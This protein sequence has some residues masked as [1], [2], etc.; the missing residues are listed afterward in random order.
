MK[1]PSFQFVYW[2]PRWL[3]PSA[4]H[5]CSLMDVPYPAQRALN[6]TYG[7][8][9]N[10]LPL[11]CL[12]VVIWMFLFSES[13]EGLYKY[14]AHKYNYSTALVRKSHILWDAHSLITV[15]P[16]SLHT[17]INQREWKARRWPR[18]QTQLGGDQPPWIARI[19]CLLRKPLWFGTDGQVQLPAGTP[20]GRED[21][22]LLSAVPQS[23]CLWW[24]EKLF[25]EGSW[26]AGE[27]CFTG[28]DFCVDLETEVMAP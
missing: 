15:L 21:G 2:S 23:R 27:E 19:S 8:E 1:A 3:F 20:R 7:Q 22:S 18:R 9:I 17:S 6:T 4:A 10:C 13:P 16:K 26:A 12:Y 11:G 5:V 14:S 28:I 25:Q 24:R